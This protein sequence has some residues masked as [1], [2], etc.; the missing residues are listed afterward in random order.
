MIFIVASPVG[1]SGVSSTALLLA[2]LLRESA[3]AVRFI[4]LSPTPDT[5]PIA[6]LGS[7]PGIHVERASEGVSVAEDAPPERKFA[8]AWECAQFAM[9]TIDPAVPTVVDLP[10]LFASWAW[11]HVRAWLDAGEMPGLRVLLILPPTIK[12]VRCMD[13]MPDKV[14]A[15]LLLGFPEFYAGSQRILADAP[16]RTRLVAAGAKQLTI[17]TLSWGSASATCSAGTVPVGANAPVSVFGRMQVRWGLSRFA[18]G[19]SLISANCHNNID[20]QFSIRW[21]QPPP[22]LPAR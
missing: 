3:P 12:S 7:V 9:E 1:G 5:S 21:S 17:P 4:D 15:A 16:A 18:K 11:P 2:L 6:R 8:A 19:L 22:T 14:A 13:Y 10:Y 20:A